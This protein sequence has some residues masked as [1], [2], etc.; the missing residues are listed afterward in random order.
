MIRHSEA[1]DGR[2][3]PTLLALIP[4]VCLGLV[5]AGCGT[6]ASESEIRAGVAGGEVSLSPETLDQL[7]A[8]SGAAS[9]AT[10]AAPPA[11]GLAS[12][13]QPAGPPAPSSTAKA[14]APGS[15]RPAPAGPVRADAGACQRALDPVALGQ[16]GTFTGIAGPIA[17]DALLAIGAW[18]KDVNSRGGLACHPVVLYSRDDGG[19]PARASAA[20]RELLDE[21]HVVA[22]LANLTPL[23]QSGFLPE[24]E[25]RCVPAIG[26]DIGPEWSREPC[27]FPQGGGYEERIAGAVAQSIDRGHHR[28]GLL[29]CVE[30]AACTTTGKDLKIQA[31]RRGATLAYSSA[32][33]LTQTDFT[34]QCQNAKNA[35][36][37]ELTVALEGS[38][39]ARLA[40]S[41]LALNYRPL[42]VGAAF[43]LNPHQAADPALR[44]LG[45]ATTNPNVPWFLTDQPGLREYQAALARYAPQAANSGITL[46]MWAAAKVLEAGIARLGDSARRGPLTSAAI[47]LGLN[48]IHGETLAGLS[49]PLDF[50]F[51]ADGT[52]SSRCVFAALLGA[53][54]WVAPH[55]STPWCNLTSGGTR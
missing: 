49:A 54:G 30:V 1:P 27:L 5:M 22:F 21:R 32:V 52:R 23:S 13:V 20:V 15:G 39:M 26:I 48:S 47:L 31:E 17:G 16:V 28:L 7:R 40:R 55:G 50:R 2:R 35:G 19:D 42:L 14:V 34:A 51:S 43:A 46:Q 4:V 38:A 36:V 24:I 45:L 11:A 53:S 18:V 12:P 8:A 6:R 41:C 44:E 9:T 37:E 10:A 29:Y 25:K 3:R 33:S